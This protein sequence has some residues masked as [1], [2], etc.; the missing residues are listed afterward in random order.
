MKALLTL[1]PI[2]RHPGG[3]EDETMDDTPKPA[4]AELA[5]TLKF[6]ITNRLTGAVQFECELSAEIAGQSFSLR[7]G[8]AVR[9]AIE[10]RANLAGANL[11]GANLAGANL[12]RA[13]LAG[14][15]LADANLTRANLADAKWRDDV[16]LQRAPLQ[17]FGLAY[18][19][20]VLDAHMQI[21]CELHSL[22][23]WA[24][25]D[26]RRI[27]EMDGKYALKFW[28]AHKAALFALAASDGRGVKPADATEAV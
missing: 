16:I 8:F 1:P 14:A 21:G 6:Q 24:T 18:P 23:E 7:L 13:N 22:A 5:E 20:V 10:A 9:K 28:H 25:F 3:T 11:A 17:L 2:T 27:A 19:V 4:P 26:D 12:A 15:Y